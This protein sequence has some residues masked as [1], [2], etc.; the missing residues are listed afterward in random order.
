MAEEAVV[1]ASAARTA[2]LQSAEV[3]CP[4]QYSGMFLLVDV[5]AITATPVLTVNLEVHCDTINEWFTFFTAS[6]TITAISETVYFIGRG[7]TA[8][9]GVAQVGGVTL[10][11]DFRLNMTHADTDS[12][13][14]SVTAQWVK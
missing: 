3:L 2:T 8:S 13:T 6:A 1:L 11:P 5:T 14:Y 7:A 9:N 10:P 4:K 12:A